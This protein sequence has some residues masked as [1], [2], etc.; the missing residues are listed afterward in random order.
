MNLLAKSMVRAIRLKLEKDEDIRRAVAQ[1]LK[2]ESIVSDLP[3]GVAALPVDP[4]FTNVLQID[5][6]RTWLPPELLVLFSL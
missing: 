3:E 4:R 2:E 6:E 1:R 5:L